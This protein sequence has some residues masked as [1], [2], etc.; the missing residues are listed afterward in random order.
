MYFKTPG[1][2]PALSVE[3]G[4]IFNTTAIVEGTGLTTSTCSRFVF[5]AFFNIVST[6]STTAYIL[7]SSNSNYYVTRV[8]ANNTWRVYVKN[9]ASSVLSQ[10][11]FTQAPLAGSGWHHIFAYTDGVDNTKSFGFFDGV[12]NGSDV[13]GAN[14]TID[15]SATNWS[16]GSSTSGASNVTCGLSQ[17][18]AGPV[19]REVTREDVQMFI[20]DGY[21]GNLGEDGS[22]PFGSKP[23]FYFPG[24]F[25]NPGVNLGTA[26]N[27]SSVVA[28][29]VDN[30]VTPIKV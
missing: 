18:W 14:G 26:G 24:D 25:T 21:P 12:A 5:S 22:I 29:I 6:D 17:V 19:D 8:S 3:K 4:S 1:G 13:S 2:V 10:W 15:T 28:S 9:A 20:K 16:L 27:F 30:T 7:F 11:R 23:F